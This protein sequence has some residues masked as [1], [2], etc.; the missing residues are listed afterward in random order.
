MTL[1]YV[2][3]PYFGAEYGKCS[4]VG[5]YLFSLYQ[6]TL[7]SNSTIRQ[8]HSTTLP[9]YHLHTA[10]IEIWSSIS[11]WLIVVR[12]IVNPT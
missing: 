12:E 6:H 3:W 5:I 8:H 10:N 7:T 1:N 2:L 9:L 4:F 11:G